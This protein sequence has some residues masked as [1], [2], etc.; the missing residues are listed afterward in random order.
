VLKNLFDTVVTVLLNPQVVHSLP[1]RLRINIPALR[2]VPENW[3]LEEDSVAGLVK[4][5][6]GIHSVSLSYITGNLLIQY[7]QEKITE[8]EIIAGIQKMGRALLQKRRQL[9]EISPEKLPL[10]IKRLDDYFK[11]KPALNFQEVTI[12]DDVWS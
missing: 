1:G 8:D 5:L 2:R 3:R 11:Q 12:P 7:D 10:Y 9:A 4:S 6:P